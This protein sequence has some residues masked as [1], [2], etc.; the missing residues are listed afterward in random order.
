MLY[1]G[2][3]RLL[4]R[5][6]YKT[7]TPVA[8]MAKILKNKSGKSKLNPTT[9]KLLNESFELVNCENIPYIYIIT[10]PQ[11]LVLSERWY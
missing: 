3:F 8:L 9:S 1:R 2:V 11:F 5:T 7:E 10:F 6:S 4:V